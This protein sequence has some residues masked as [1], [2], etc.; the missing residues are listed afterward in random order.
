MPPSAFPGEP[1]ARGR[2]AHRVA[3]RGPRRERAPRG[4]TTI[5]IQWRH[6]AGISPD[7]PDTSNV[8]RLSYRAAGMVCARPGD[9]QRGRAEGA[10]GVASTAV[11][12]PSNP[13]A[14]L[15][16]LGLAAALVL[17][18]GA[19]CTHEAPPGP[20]TP[21]A[22]PAGASG[23]PRSVTAFGA[24]VRVSAPPQRVL[25]AT[26]AALDFLV[27]LVG[28]ERI[29]AVP[30]TAPEYA[31]AALTA[32]DWGRLPTFR[33]F[34]GE[35]ILPLRPDL[36]VTHDY[37]RAE[38]SRVL[39]QAGVPVVRLPD[40][41]SFEDLLGALRTLGAVVGEEE[42]AAQRIGELA[43]RRAA[44][45]EDDSLAGVR[46]LTYLDLG[47][48][49]WTAG[50]RTTGDLLI[51]LAGLA[52]AA[53]EAG[54]VGN[55]ELDQERLITLDPDLIVVRST[56]D[57]EGSVATLALLRSSPTLSALRAVREER[58]VVLPARLFAAESH[59]V[60]DGAEL[61]RTRTRRQLGLGP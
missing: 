59:Y 45:G 47:T 5:H 9:L 41:Q 36:V 42:R 25:P 18:A 28:V 10:P 50:A 23:F 51:R 52:N 21:T 37:Q 34:Q 55:V 46:A 53:A 60:L 16:P 29:V 43:R 4:G 48:G 6:R 7:F 56:V 26:A 15:A 2:C 8:Q 30:F 49:G 27:D 11:I 57:G 19:A 31:G 44:L 40:M 22:A 33:N 61:L 1:N 17:G 24:Q 38:A 14:L 3:T 35:D 12:R 20:A 58:V 13:A 32:G 39:Q 54:L